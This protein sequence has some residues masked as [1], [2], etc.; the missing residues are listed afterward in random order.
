M[1]VAMGRET[2]VDELE[3]S[4][5]LSA[6]L[7]AL[8]V[9]TVGELC[10]LPE[11]EMPRA[12]AAELQILLAEMDLE[13]GG[14]LITGE[15]Q[16]LTCSGGVIARWGTVRSWLEEHHADVLAR[17]RPPADPQD[18]ANAERTLGHALPEDYKRFLSMHD[19]QEPMG[20]WVATCTL[21]PVGAL[22][23]KHSQLQKLIATEGVK[24]G[25]GWVP[26][27][28]SVRGREYLC[29]DLDHATARGQVMALNLDFDER[30][31]VAP[32]FTELLSVF[33]EQMQRGELQTA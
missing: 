6:F 19:G 21:L 14:K 23:A 17:F 26:I 4:A 11:L 16:L 20:P 27:G 2:L 5:P 9:E 15:A 24:C 22:P 12:L 10:D 33:F 7:S 30:P 29:L 32:S 1:R 3:V 8:G 31:C 28:Q 13:L 18:I 25:A